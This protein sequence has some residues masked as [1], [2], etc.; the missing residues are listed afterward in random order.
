MCH[1]SNDAKFEEEW[2]CRLKTDLMNL[3]HFDWNTQKSQKFA[4]EWFLLNE[5]YNY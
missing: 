4:L 5:V 1:F 2:T 3:K